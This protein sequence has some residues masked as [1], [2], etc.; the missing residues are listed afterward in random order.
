MNQA[1]C[2]DCMTA[3]RDM[4]DG[5]F[6]LAVVDPPYGRK[7]HGG[8]ARSGWVRQKSGS[9]LYV[10]DGHYAKKTWDLTPPLANISK[11]CAGYPRHRSSGA[12]I[13][14]LMCWARGVSSGISAM[15][16]ATSQIVR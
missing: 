1:F 6:D 5:A 9:M 15:G 16:A 10:E 13:T 11:N 8:K 12:V 14:T 4:P 3:M 7:E 2:Q